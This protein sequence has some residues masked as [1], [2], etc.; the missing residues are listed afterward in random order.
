MVTRK[1]AQ[2]SKPSIHLDTSGALAFATES[3][4]AGQVV[5]SQRRV[6][7]EATKAVSGLVPVGD[8]RLTANI[9]EHLH[10]KLKMESVTRR[11]TIGELLEELIE[12]HL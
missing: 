3:T 8:V 2:I 11:T 5:E 9:K 7:R 6:S 1:A 10:M 12:R 4:E